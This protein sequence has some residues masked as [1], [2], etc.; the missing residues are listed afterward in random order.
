M[1]LEGVGEGRL[2]IEEGGLESRE[3]EDIESSLLNT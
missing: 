3:P 2:E 1:E